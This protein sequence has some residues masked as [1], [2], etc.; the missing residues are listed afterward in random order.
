[1][2]GKG[3]SGFFGGIHPTDGFDKA[4]TDQKP[5]RNYEPKTVTIYLNQS[6]TGGCRPLVSQG[7]RVTQGQL[8]AR[9]EGFARDHLHASVTGRVVQIKEVEEQ[10]K[11]RE[12]FVIE[13]ETDRKEPEAPEK[14]RTYEEGFPDLSGYT[15]A[16][17]LKGIM[18]GGLVGMGGAGFPTYKKYNGQKLDW[19]LINA[20]ECEPYLTCDHRLMLEEGYRVLNGVRLLLK[21]SGA[22]K[23]YICMEENKQ[24]AAMHLMELMAGSKEQGKEV[25]GKD[26]L[27][28]S[29][30]IRLLPVRYPQGG[31]RQLIQT[32]LGV[33]V[34]MGGLPASVGAVVSNVGTAA[35]AC[36]AVLGGKPLTH[37]IV[38]VT[39]LVKEPGNYRV[40]LGTPIR[41][42]LSA[43]GGVSAGKNRVIIGGP[44][45]GN[46]AAVDWDGEELPFVTKTTSGVVVLPEFSSEEQPCIRC[47]GCA[48]VCPAGLTPFQIDSAYREEDYDLC[49][50]LYA[51]ECIACGCCSYICP[52]R[53]ELTWTVRSARDMVKQR[54]RER[55]AAK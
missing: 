4:L 51:S 31:E 10:G 22:R 42:L 29:V 8:I 11:F 20:A 1:M 40:P 18:E 52:A 15:R 9:S 54:M 25:S 23:A 6:L 17:I 36:D 35:A 39:G 16:D 14:N 55:K 33:E 24:D 3:K 53:R 13:R 49:E 41:E 50:T 45:T 21:A 48:Q 28:E 47:G 46:C 19:L 2:A 34:P 26:R 32:V 5:V 38:T 43:C 27:Q 30:E 7:D 44:M 12:A 37:R